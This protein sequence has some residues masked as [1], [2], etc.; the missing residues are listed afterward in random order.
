MRIRKVGIVLIVAVIGV[1][2][3]GSASAQSNQS[4]WYG[5]LKLGFNSSQFR[6]DPVSQWVYNPSGGYHLNGAV[7]DK[8]YGFIGG[9]FFR[10]DFSD[11][12]ALQ[13]DLL[14]SMRGGQGPVSGNITVNYPGN[15]SDSGMVNGELQVR[16]DYIELPLLAFFR[17]PRDPHDRSGFTVEVGPAVAYNSRAEAQLT[18]DVDVT[19]P[20]GPRVVKFD[21]RIPIQ[22][23]INRWA[24]SGI[25]GAAVE[26]YLSKQTIILEGRYTFDVTSITDDQSSYNHVF[27]L[28]VA[29]MARITT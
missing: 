26:I 18:G 6:G 3:G 22:G 20:D 4:K 1:A 16:M 24:V 17:F 19:L 27:S 23:D 12:F 5:G 14:Y 7:A 28:M 13:L 2:A 29:F 11:W 9:G 15:I 25:V 8:L 21:Q 10:R